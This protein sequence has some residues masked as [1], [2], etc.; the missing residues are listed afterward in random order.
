MEKI[1]NEPKFKS[2]KDSKKKEK[3]TLK[4]VWDDFLASFIQEHRQQIEIYKPKQEIKTPLFNSD[5]VVTCK[6]GDFFMII[7]GN[8]WVYDNADEKK[9]EHYSQAAFYPDFVRLNP[10]LF[11]KQTK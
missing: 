1:K 4:G 5:R 8:V 10:N 6:V 3:K 2:K 9:K 7:E 11:E